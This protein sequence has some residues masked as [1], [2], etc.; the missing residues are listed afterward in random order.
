[1]PVTAAVARIERGVDAGADAH[2]EH[3]IA[4]LDAHPLNRLHAAGVQRRTEHEV[5]DRGELFVDAL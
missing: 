1:M 2:L 4:G 5:V 3:P